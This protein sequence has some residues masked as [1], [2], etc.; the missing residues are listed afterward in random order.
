M[1]TTASP[2]DL[3]TLGRRVRH[4]REAQRLTLAELGAKVGCTA[5][6][7]STIENGRREPRLRLL[8][9][10][11]AALSVPVAE[12]L[13]PAP[14]S[15]R[16]ALEISLEQA[17][18]DPAYL[19]L[20]LPEVRPGRRLPADVLEALVGL[21]DELRAQVLRR[22]ATPEEARR[23]NVELRARMRERDNYYAAIEQ[24][25]A[26]LLDGV[27]HVTGPLTHQAIESI[28]ENL[29]FTLH[30]V[31]DLPRS[32]R[33]VTDLRHRRI[34]L[35]RPNLTSGH[36]PRMVVLQ[37][38]GHFVLG[39]ADPVDYADFLRQ[40][41]EANY[42]SAAMLMPEAAVVESLQ[43][44]KRERDIAVEDLRDMFAVSY[45]TAAHRF[46]NL[47]THHL[48]LPVHFMRVHESGTIY[49]AYENDG[50]C[51][52]TD[53][54]GAIEGQLGCRAWAART[55]FS[56]SDRFTSYAQYTDTPAGTYWCAAHVE[57]SL[58]GDY[59]IAVGV[60]YAH[61]KWFRGRD[62]TRRLRST[63]PDPACCRQPAPALLARWAGQAWPSA[64][65]HSHLLAALP[66]GTFPGVDET[67]VYSFLERRAGAAP[68]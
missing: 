59:A 53:P 2:A 65:A 31:G 33:S 36:D 3:L 67:D 42:F 60:P 48:G 34:Y 10:I 14:P 15:R 57:P 12:L 7:L 27:R 66:P 47:A 6:H 18:R 23:A 4:L 50:V 55:V 25:I 63:C 49:K 19:A 37:T 1:T 29:G 5:S 16:A 21:H 30:H 61:A 45:E 32:T 28:A 13:Q 44:A 20:G 11:A 56:S 8:H 35:P 43:R 58:G 40:R 26:P 46:T 68:A 62:T 52:P 51:F 9:D 41:V 38:L 64:R 24:S 22:A 17:Q 39:H 54:I